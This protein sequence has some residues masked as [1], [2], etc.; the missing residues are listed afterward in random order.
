MV[1]Q[2]IGKILIMNYWLMKS[3]PTA[4]SID[5]LASRPAQT[6]AWDGVRNY[7]AR[8]MMRDQM[9]CGDLAFF[10]HSSCAEPG[11]VGIVEIVGKAHP[12]ITALDPK[13]HHYD[14]KSTSEKPIWC[15]VDIQL[16]QK[17]ARPIN[18]QTLRQQLKLQE[19]VILRK[20]NRL[21]IT[22]ITPEEWKTILA[23]V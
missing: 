12:D 6:E 1:W 18:L 4:F 14:P 22:P 23:L 13:N 5:D 2:T 17:F 10:Y 11:I 20:G 19:M 21:S 7:Q 16:K 8:N 3:E 9:R 15:C